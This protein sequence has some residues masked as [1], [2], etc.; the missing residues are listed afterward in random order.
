MTSSRAK[1]GVCVDYTKEATTAEL[2]E[3]R[4]SL[5]CSRVGA[6]LALPSATGVV[7]AGF[8]GFE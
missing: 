6:G 8:D 1:K 3:A 7:D 2:D 5:A 4:R